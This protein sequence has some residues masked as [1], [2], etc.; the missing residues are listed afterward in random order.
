MPASPHNKLQVQVQVQ[1]LSRRFARPWWFAA[2]GG[3]A[4]PGCLGPG[5]TLEPSAGTEG[6]QE[7]AV[8]GAPHHLS[9]VLPLH[10]P[11]P[12][13]RSGAC[14]HPAR[15]GSSHEELGRYFPDEKGVGLWLCV[16]RALGPCPPWPTTGG[17]PT[18]EASGNRTRGPSLG[19]TGVPRGRV[20][21]VGACSTRPLCK[22]GA[23]LSGLAPLRGGSSPQWTRSRGRARR[24][25]PEPHGGGHRACGQTGHSTWGGG[26]PRSQPR[27]AAFLHGVF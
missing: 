24:C 15:R 26:F 27:S 21:R 20:C 22:P 16:G 11:P 2:L 10:P 1:V 17:V 13:P 9:E 4:V 23:C 12:P 7:P 6:H 3:V 18:P 25:C 8:P 14:D 5:G 19:G